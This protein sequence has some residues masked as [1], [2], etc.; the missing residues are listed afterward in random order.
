MKP[1]RKL[2]RIATVVTVFAFFAGLVNCANA[3][4]QVPKN[5]EIFFS[6]D[7]KNEL[8]VCGC[9]EKLGGLARRKSAIKQSKYP[10]VVVDCGEFSKGS[11]RLEILKTETLLKC[12][13]S[14][15]YDVIN[16]GGVEKRIGRKLM[17]QFDKV[18]DAPF[19]SANIADDK[20]KLVYPPYK[21]VTVGGL[22]LGFIGVTS[23]AFEKPEPVL[24][25]MVLDL[26]KQLTKYLPELDKQS[27][28]IIVLASVRDNELQTIATKHANVNLVLGGRT[29]NYSEND[30]PTKV[31]STI[32][33]KTGSIG[34]Y[35]GRI[36]LDLQ[37]ATPVKIKNYEGYNIELDDEYKDDPDIAKILDAHK[38]VLKTTDFTK[39][40]SASTGTPGKPGAKSEEIPIADASTDSGE[41]PAF[42][43]YTS[44]VR[45]ME[46]HPD[47]YNRWRRSE[48][49]NA[50]RTLVDEN[51]DDNPQCYPCH[52][53][54]FKRM[55]GFVDQQ[56]TP[57]LVGVQCESCHGGGAA[58]V[59]A[60][61]DKTKSGPA[62]TKNVPEF[63]CIRCH[64]EEWDPGFSM[65]KKMPIVDHGLDKSPEKIAD[66][67]E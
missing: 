42:M 64:N 34:K 20:G 14:I 6:A 19:I 66:P 4:S 35:L 32:I 25:F 22:K 59:L 18:A 40:D 53:V 41:T 39:K 56:S 2:F 3:A 17:D 55:G 29:F 43:G 65:A 31:A 27:D 57:K 13:N 62:I 67:V 11:T 21:I 28:L 63:F 49:A 46:C 37:Q 8:F 48:H 12:Y 7:T 16:M 24:G 38:K 51:E 45:C 33:H 36:R 54:G 1:I 5:V 44:A 61:K 60:M 58:H 9:K 23:S 15:K 52:A 10:H 30:R 47:I 26:E 50:F